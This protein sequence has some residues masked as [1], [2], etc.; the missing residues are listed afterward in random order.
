MSPPPTSTRSRRPPSGSTRGEP[1]PPGVRDAATSSTSRRPPSTSCSPRTR[2]TRARSRSGSSRGSARPP[3]AGRACSSA[4]PGR[5]V[6]PAAGDA[7][8]WSS[9]PGRSTRRRPSRTARS[10]RRASSP[11]RRARIGG[12][13]PARSEVAGVPSPSRRLRDGYRRFRQHPLPDRA[14]ALPPARGGRPAPDDDG[15]R[16][17]RLPIRPR[18]RL[19]R[20]ARRAVRRPQR[21]RRS[22]RCTRRTRGA[23]PPSAALEYAVL[24][25]GVRSIV[26][27]GHG[28]CGG[29]ATALDDAAPLTSTDFIGTWVAGLRDLADELDPVASWADP[30][31][32]P[33]RRSSCRTVE[34]S[35]VNLRTFPWIRS[36]EAPGSFA[37]P[38]PG[39]TSGSA[40]SGRSA[41]GGWRRRPGDASTVA[42]SPPGLRSTRMSTDENDRRPLDRM[43]AWQAVMAHHATIRDRH[44]RDLFAD[45]PGRADPPAPP[46]APACSWTTRKHRVTDETMALLLAVAGR[47]ASRSAGPRCSA[48][49]GSTGPRTARSSTRPCAPPPTSTR[50]GRRPRRRPGRPRGPRP[51]GGVRAQGPPRR[52]EG[53]HRQADPQRRQ[54]RHRRL[55]P[56]ARHGDRGAAQLRRALDALPVRVQR[57]R[58]RHPRRDRWTSTRPRRCSSSAARRSRRSRR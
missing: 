5:Q 8:S 4:T 6:P 25:L 56:R 45:D 31:R 48:A 15:R 49:S 3:R 57:R 17:L 55:R 51:D 28:R 50:R 18:D 24:A 7:G 21:R 27:M 43:P 26:V 54:H 35:V 40:S 20:A 14:R 36:R 30:E 47:R 10:S 38:A 22:S 2:G 16:L 46:R 52:V 58:H 23:T 42:R 9:P 41:D 33:P 12:R 34:Q 37:C 53:L 1:R 32:A 19:R 44:L 11:C 39:S 13:P 29:V